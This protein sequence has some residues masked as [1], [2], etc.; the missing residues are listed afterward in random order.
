MKLD[1]RFINIVV[2]VLFIGSIF[3]SDSIALPKYKN[4][5]IGD[6]IVLAESVSEQ[7]A[8]EET[9]AKIN[10]TNL[11]IVKVAHREVGNVGGEKFWSYFGFN[12]YQAWCCCFVSWCADQCGFIEDGTFPKFTSVKHGYEL[13]KSRNQWIS[14]RETPEPGMVVFFAY[15]DEEGNY[16]GCNHVGLVKAVI[17]GRVY[18][19]EGNYNNTCCETEYVIGHPLIVGYG[20]PDYQ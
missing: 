12:T 16:R 18:C 9:L 10:A 3:K 15:P 4:T 5:L 19:I 17:D 2:L 7:E 13:F 8:K 6:T 14:G 1:R 20:T 11:N